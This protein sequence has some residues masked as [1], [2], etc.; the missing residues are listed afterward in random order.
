MIKHILFYLIHHKITRS[1]VL[2]KIPVARL[3]LI[4]LAVDLT[5]PFAIDWLYP[6]LKK[7]ISLHLPKLSA[8]F[9]KRIFKGR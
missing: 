4:L 2:K 8:L 9:K 1:A 7:K 5:L 6:R 3:N